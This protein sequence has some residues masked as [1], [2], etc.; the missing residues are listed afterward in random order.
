[1]TGDRRSIARCVREEDDHIV[2]PNMCKDLVR[3]PR[4]TDRCNTDC[5]VR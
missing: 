4:V 3:P 2:T 1:M 5:T